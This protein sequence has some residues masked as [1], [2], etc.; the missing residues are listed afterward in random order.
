MSLAFISNLELKSK[1]PVSMQFFSLTTEDLMWRKLGY[2][3]AEGTWVM[4]KPDVMYTPFLTNKIVCVKKEGV[5]RDAEASVTSFG[6]TAYLRVNVDEHPIVK[7]DDNEI[8]YVNNSPECVSNIYSINRATKQVTGIR[9]PNANIESDGCKGLQKNEIKLKLV[10]GFDVWQELQ[11]EHTHK[12]INISILILLLFG[13]IF[14][15]YLVWRKK[16]VTLKT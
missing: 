1:V 14:G 16:K 2:V 7:W 9:K 3:V 4:E 11:A 13:Y 8:V 5:C 15:L 6:E 10:S 12:F